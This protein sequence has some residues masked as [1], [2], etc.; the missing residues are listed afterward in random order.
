MAALV[1]YLGRTEVSQ[2]PSR[3]GGKGLRAKS[4]IGTLVE[5]DLRLA[6]RDPA[7]R[8]SLAAGLIGP[9]LVL[10]LLSGGGA[11][12]GPVSA[13]FLGA[14]LGLTA[15]GMNVFALERRAVTL[16]LAFPV[17]RWKLLV[18]KSV[19]QLLLRSPVVIG[20][21]AAI[22]LMGSARTA[23]AAALTALCVWLVGSGADGVVS[24]LHPLA[25]AAPGGSPTAHQAGVSGLASAGWAMA[26]LAFVVVA[27][28]PFVFLVA[29]PGLLEMPWL[30]LGAL[31]LAMAGSLAVHVMLVGAAER[32][33]L[34]REASVLARAVGSA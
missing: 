33:L 11:A 24:V 17:P 34:S 22:A 1:A 29:L 32:L 10:L 6:W 27:S 14:F 30:R 8:M 15:S 23:S 19:V 12:V 31:P 2:G 21:L 4:V 5:K 16:L 13:I 28:A 9:L 25:F 7:L 26:R 18:A 20:L 3:S